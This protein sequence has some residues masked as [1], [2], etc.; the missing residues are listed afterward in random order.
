MTNT[1][2][3]GE[4]KK[5]LQAFSFT[6]EMDGLEE[7]IVKEVTGFGAD[8]PPTEQVQGC[9]KRGQIA[10]QSCPTP[11]QATKLTIKIVA[12]NEKD[13]SDWYQQC[14][15]AFGDAK[16]IEK[17]DGS[18]I[19]YGAGQEEIARWELKECYP[20]KYSGMTLNA[21]AKDML[22]ETFELD[23]IDIERTL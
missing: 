18:I 6:I 10:R 8:S 15:S 4:N 16:N 5:F 14:N 9:G 2:N 23:V 3:I 17:K 22:T 13:F 1:A 12:S 7:K 21:S 19:A 20:T 11:K